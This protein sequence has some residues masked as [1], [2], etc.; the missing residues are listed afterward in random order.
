[1]LNNGWEPEAVKMI[2]VKN[3]T[4]HF[5]NKRVIDDLSVVLEEGRVTT[6]MGTSGCGK[7]TFAMMLLGLLQP[8]AGTIEGLE[9]KRLS[10]VFQE[11]RLVEHLS[12]T[13]NIKLVL[14]KDADAGNI[15]EQLAMVGLE[16]ELIRK[17]VGH[18]SG[19][20]KRRV[21]IV[22]AM[23]AE[24]DFIFLDEP[25]KGLDAETKEK[26]M[27]YVKRCVEGKTVLLITHDIEERRYFGGDF[28]GAIPGPVCEIFPF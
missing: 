12:A 10:A 4:K 11:D 19:G 20:Q 2:T 23:M 22:R 5:D 18:L 27:E 24:S 15:Q 7:T 17:S 13:A 28:I 8:D 21:A 6:V 9:N 1:M 26:V 3:L 14:K 25:F 16:G